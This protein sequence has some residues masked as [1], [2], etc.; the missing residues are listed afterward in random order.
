MVYA[1]YRLEDQTLAALGFADKASRAPLQPLEAAHLAK[2]LADLDQLDLGALVPIGFPRRLAAAV[3]LLGLAVAISAWSVCAGRPQERSSDAVEAVAPA[4][5]T[6]EPK[7]WPGDNAKVASPTGGH[8]PSRDEVQWRPAGSGRPAEGRAAP[9]DGGPWEQIAADAEEK[10][11]GGAGAAL[12]AEDTAPSAAGG[13]ALPPEPVS[14]AH[15][16]LIRR[17]VGSLHQ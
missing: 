4:V 15:Q 1:H 10:G 7:D 14:P 13:A 12:P 11:G 2:A 3:G 6:P 9:W 17:Y 16:Y 5:Q 8:G